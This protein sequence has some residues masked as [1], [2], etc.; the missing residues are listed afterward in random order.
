MSSSDLI[1]SHLIYLIISLFYSWRIFII[2][3]YFSKRK[4]EKSGVYGGLNRN[5]KWN[6]K[7]RWP[8]LIEQVPLCLFV[9]L[10][11]KKEK[12]LTSIT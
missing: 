2:I 11:Q 5:S 4:E 1:N 12:P 6:H 9:L 7:K 10:L 8:H 3:F